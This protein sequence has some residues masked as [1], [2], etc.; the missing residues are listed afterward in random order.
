MTGGLRVQEINVF[1]TCIDPTNTSA[2]IPEVCTCALMQYVTVAYNTQLKIVGCSVWFFQCKRKVVRASLLPAIIRW[3]PDEKHHNY[4][5]PFCYTATLHARWSP[6]QYSTCMEQQVTCHELSMYQQNWEW[7][8]IIL[9][10]MRSLSLGMKLSFTTRSLQP[11]ATG[12]PAV[13]VSLNNL[14]YTC[15]Y[16]VIGWEMKG[17]VVWYLSHH[18]K[19]I[20]FF[21]CSS[22]SS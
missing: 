6:Q 8:V 10:V 21:S 19:N 4:F 7:S 11:P 9:G 3:K 14:Y 12:H 17:R 1:S 20:L 18:W 22:Q 16:I 15:C 5:I 2:N 13:A